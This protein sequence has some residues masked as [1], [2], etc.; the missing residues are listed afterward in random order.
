M[1][2]E[3]E[4]PHIYDELHAANKKETS[5]KHN[6]RHRWLLPVGIVL[7]G[8]VC[9]VA[10]FVISYFAVPARGK[11]DVIM[12]AHTFPKVCAYNYCVFLFR[13]THTSTLCVCVKKTHAIHS[14]EVVWLCWCVYPHLYDGTLVT[15]AS[16]T[17]CMSLW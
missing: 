14:W 4:P 2:Q 12:H 5:T 6:S 15:H 7:L 16:Q 17:R 9:F 10:G 13:R 1:T 8:V 11:Y 3:A